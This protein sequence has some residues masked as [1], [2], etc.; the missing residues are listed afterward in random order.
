MH[1][2]YDVI[3]STVFLLSQDGKKEEYAFFPFLLEKFLG[4][5]FQVL[6]LEE[7]FSNLEPISQ[8]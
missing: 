8:H 2:M 7:G 5:A 1:G 3:V 4:F 6:T